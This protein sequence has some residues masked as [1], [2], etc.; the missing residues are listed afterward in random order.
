MEGKL[1][2]LTAKLYQEGIE[3]SKAEGKTLIDNAKKDADTVLNDAR[4]EAELIVGNAKKEA[5]QLKNKVASELKMSGSQMMITLKHDI[6]D[7][8]LKASLSTPISNAF[9]D[10]EFVKSIIKDIL[11]KWNSSDKDMDLMLVMPEKQKEDFTNF[12]KYEAKE[13]FNK[14]IELKFESR[15]DGGFKILPKDNSFILSFTDNDFNQ[16]F[17]SFLKQ[18]IKDI[19]FPGE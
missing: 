13:L 16:F 2:E 19:L 5:E 9:N 11:T 7:V 1:Q 12:F 8:L 3:K 4:K 14:G 10:T 6:M 15:I 18:S 17:Q